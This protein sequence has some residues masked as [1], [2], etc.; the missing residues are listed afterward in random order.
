MMKVA[1]LNF[2]HD[3]R[4]AIWRAKVHFPN[5]YAASVIYGDI[6]MPD[7]RPGMYELAVFGPDGNLDYS[8][9]VT[10]NVERGDAAE[11]EFLMAQIEALPPKSGSIQP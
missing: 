8:T 2:K 7:W 1:D 3:G 4:M 10:S 11:I 9:P 6:V 5:G